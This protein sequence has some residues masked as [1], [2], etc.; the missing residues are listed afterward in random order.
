MYDAALDELDIE[1]RDDR[2]AAKPQPDEPG[3][4]A[5]DDHHHDADAEDE[6]RAGQVRLEQHQ[7]RDHTQH[8]RVRDDAEAQRLHFVA[9]FGDTVGEEH[10]DGELRN[11]RGL[12]RD[13]LRA[14][15]ARGIVA[16]LREG[17]VWDNDEDQQKNC[18]AQQNLRR[19]APALVVD[20]ADDKH[21]RKAKRGK[22][23]LP[24]EVIR[25]VA[26]LIVGRGE[27]RRKEHQQS[28]A[29]QQQRQQQQRQI[30]R[31]LRR[32][33]AAPLDLAA[34]LLL[35]LV[36]VIFLSCHGFSPFPRDFRF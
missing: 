36:R 34:A 5:A 20:L 17:V 13:G 12:E 8:R 30:E 21:H 33:I 3:L 24:L 32:L 22:K 19:A 16:R 23:R 29:R 1:H 25:R 6:D 14:Q 10:D 2:H 26:R 9:L 15:P 11:L 35:C 7:H 28:H 27:A 31:A 4:D 18:K